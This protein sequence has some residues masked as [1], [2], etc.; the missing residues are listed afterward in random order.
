MTAPPSALSDLPLQQGFRRAMGN[1]ASPV[2]VVT[3]STGDVPHGTTVSAFTSL[4]MEPPQV[5]VS[6][7]N[8]SQLLARLAP[9][10]RFGLNV[11]SA[12]Q[13]QI[14]LRFAQRRDDKFADIAW[15]SRDEAPAL[16]GVHAWVAATAGQF[17]ESGDHTIV[18]GSVVAAEAFEHAPLT[19]W[20]RS[21]GTHQP[22]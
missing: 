16:V 3:T 9:G 19:Y 8:S 7:A 15:R 2:A 13:D 5:L 18:V 10:S 20:Q 11:L 17:V 1:V 21:F 14:A 4:S 12:H 6:L 22:F